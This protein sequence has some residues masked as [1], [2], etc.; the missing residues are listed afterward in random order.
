MKKGYIFL[1]MFV[2][3]GFANAQWQKINS[4]SDCSFTCFAAKG[5]TVLAGS[6]STLRA[7]D[8]GGLY[9]ST[10]NGS[11][12]TAIKMFYNSNIKAI[13]VKGS[14]IFVATGW[15]YIS[16]DNG[17]TWA[18]AN[19]ENPKST[20]FTRISNNMNSV[21]ALAING[22]NIYAGTW[23]GRIFLSKDNG[24]N[25]LQIGNLQSTLYCL[26]ANENTIFAGTGAGRGNLSEGVCFSTD[27]GTN[28]SKVKTLPKLFVYTIAI[29][30]NDIFA[31]TTSG[32]FLS[33]NNGVNWNPTGSLT[34]SVITSMAI[35]GHNILVG[36]GN[37]IRGN[38]IFGT[39][40]CVYLST[41]KGANWSKIKKGLN[42]E[43]KSSYLKIVG[44]G[45]QDKNVFAGFEVGD[46]TGWG[47]GGGIFK[48]GT[49]IK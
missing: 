32:V 48:N 33:S 36:S 17:T 25:W 24:A 49:I 18:Q 4:L 15:L 40:N 44:L 34:K 31:G 8:G 22:N 28:W 13:A 3:I 1:F 47:K 12:W 37:D 16:Y 14:A 27:N 5:D 46:D 23:D 38:D 35:S 7:S 41:D 20:N 21:V 9:L 30:G 26:A 29:C 6:K 11:N 43:S 2:T 19:D 10:D 39:D 42:L 45:I